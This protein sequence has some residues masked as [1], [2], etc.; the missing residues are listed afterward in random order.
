MKLRESKVKTFNDDNQ[1][2]SL[3]KK[4]YLIFK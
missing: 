1:E 3:N 2:L 4:Y